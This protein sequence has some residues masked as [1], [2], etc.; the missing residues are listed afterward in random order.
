[1]RN[2]LLGVFGS[3]VLLLGFTGCEKMSREQQAFEPN[4]LYAHAISV[5]Q[6]VNTDQPLADSDQLLNLWFG[7]LDE[8]KVPELIEEEFPDLLSLENLQMA[9]GPRNN[10]TRRSRALSPAVCVVPWRVRT[11][12][13]SRCSLSKSLPE[14]IP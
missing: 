10:R 11:R 12:A 9:A 8:P 7:T 6:E 5:S 3:L 4:Y 14:G 1:M 2:P 13:R